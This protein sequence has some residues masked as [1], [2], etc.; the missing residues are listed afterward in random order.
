MAGYKVPGNRSPF[1]TP[2]PV[3]VT[4]GTLTAESSNARTQSLTV[5]DENGLAVSAPVLVDVWLSD[6]ADGTGVLASAA[7]SDLAAGTNGK[8]MEVGVTGKKAQF[9][10]K[11]DGTLDVVITDTATRVGIYLCVGTKGGVAVTSAIAF[12]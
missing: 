1:A 11:A 12:A 5:T 4:F 8:L 6:N 10:T 3:G 2:G 9:Q 7:S